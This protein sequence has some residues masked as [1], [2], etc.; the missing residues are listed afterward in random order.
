[1][2]GPFKAHRKIYLD[3]H[4]HHWFIEEARTWREVYFRPT[5]EAAHKLLPF[6]CF[7]IH[8]PELL[9]RWHCESP[10]RGVALRSTKVERR[11]HN[12]EWRN[13]ASITWPQANP[14]RWPTP[15]RQ[16]LCAAYREAGARALGSTFTGPRNGRDPRLCRGIVVI[17]SKGKRAW[18]QASLRFAV[19]K[20]SREFVQPRAGSRWGDWIPAHHRLQ[21]RK[22]LESDL[23]T[24][25]EFFLIWVSGLRFVST[26]QMWHLVFLWWPRYCN[27]DPC[28][29][30]Q[31]LHSKN[32]LWFLQ[33]IP[34]LQLAHSGRDHRPPYDTVLE[35]RSG[36]L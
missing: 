19:G 27:P 5:A 29:S 23:M 8:N 6:L 21:F 34:W 4:V 18:P 7:V 28:S 30:P 26:M 25:I 1:M 15:S 16:R 17:T 24:W 33:N 14:G 10:N 3:V 22:N 36:G 32:S 12:W 31:S 13:R 9:K 11:S 35:A 20:A 2:F